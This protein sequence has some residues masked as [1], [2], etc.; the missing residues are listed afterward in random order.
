MRVW[1]IARWVLLVLWIAAMAVFFARVFSGPEDTWIRDASGRWIAHGHPAGPPPPVGYQPPAAERTL[2][3]F[4]LAFFAT[5]LLAAVLLSGR[6]PAGADSLNRGI[7][8]FGTVS[9]VSTVLAIGLAIGVA[10]TLLTSRGAMLND[11]TLIIL[12]LAGV[13]M[14]LKLL[15]W[16]AD[17]TKKVLEAHYDLKRQLALLQDTVERMSPGRANMGGSATN[18]ANST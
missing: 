8:Y 16:H 10:V 1:Q 6:S 3:A 14:L 18:V 12:C 11:P 4:L 17:S 5:G 15:S 13:A 2:P 9:I 7:R